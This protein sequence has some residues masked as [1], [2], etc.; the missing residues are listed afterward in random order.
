MRWKHITWCIISC[1][2]R[3]WPDHVNMISGI[4][5]GTGLPM[6]TNMHALWAIGMITR[7]WTLYVHVAG[8]QCLHV[9]ALTVHCKL[10]TVSTCMW[11]YMCTQYRNCRH[12]YI[13]YPH[14]FASPIDANFRGAQPPASRFYGDCSPPPPL[15]LLPSWWHVCLCSKAQFT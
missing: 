15:A 8:I 6:H 3:N 5:Y 9:T 2:K 13:W 12:M 14:L 1:A 10:P 11:S 7:G 4:R